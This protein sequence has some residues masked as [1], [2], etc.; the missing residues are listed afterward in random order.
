[1]DDVF[2]RS[3]Q[4]TIVFQGINTFLDP[5]F[6]IEDGEL[7]YARNMSCHKSPTVLSVRPGRQQYADS[8]TKPNAFGTRENQE[9]HVLDGTT[10]KR[11]D[12]EAWQ[13][14]KT[15][16]SNAA[17]KFLDF[18]DASKVHTILIN[19]TDAYSWDGNSITQLTDA[20]KSRLC[21]AHRYRLYWAT[22]NAV[23]ASDL[24][25][26]KTYPPENIMPVTNAKGPLVAINE[27]GDHVV[28]WSPYSFHEIYGDSPADWEIIDVSTDIGC[29]SDRCVV[30]HAN[31][32]WWLDINGA[33]Y[34]YGG[35][36]PAKVGQKIAKYLQEINLAY[37]HL[38]C[39]ASHKDSIYWSV[40]TYPSTVNNLIL[41]YRSDLDRWY[42]HDGNIAQFA[43]IGD[44]LYGITNDGVVLDMDSGTE[45]GE[46]AIQW[47]AITKPFHDLSI[48][49]K[50]SLRALYV[51]ADV[52]AGSSLIVSG[53]RKETGNGEGDFETLYTF[54]PADD[55]Q[56]TQILIPT[57]K[58]QLA[59]WYRLKFSGS[60]P[61]D[62]YYLH[63]AV[64]KR[65][66]TF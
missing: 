14:V 9:L 52:P 37:K 23:E 6:D 33:V 11:W 24:S 63:K 64:G 19:G 4:V 40:P 28:V 47:E 1:M 31:L 61:C 20:P 8:V 29:L 54:T 26:F 34:R 60:G 66:G 35:G 38:C 22:E 53:S 21:V 15:D 43:T 59:D 65:G 7:T 48:K 46:T 45:D 51:V 25:D 17:G 42:V 57:S 50:K 18:R 44:K 41:E 16:L 49:A 32:L 27:Y 30:K 13:T 10:W 12:G 3:D 56:N 62:I 58:L 5:G 55:L 39:G 36:L 2:A